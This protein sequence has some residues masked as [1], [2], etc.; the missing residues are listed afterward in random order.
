VAVVDAAPVHRTAPT[1]SVA[2]PDGF[3]FDG[4]DLASAIRLWERLR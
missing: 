2:T 3:F 1:I 4:L